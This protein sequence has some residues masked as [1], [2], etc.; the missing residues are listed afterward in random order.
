MPWIIEKQNMKYFILDALKAKIPTKLIEGENLAAHTR[1]FKTA[2]Y[3]Q[4]S[5]IG[6][7]WIL[8]KYVKGMPEYIDKDMASFEKCFKEDKARLCAFLYLENSDQVKYGSIMQNVVQQKSLGNDQYTKTIAE[9]NNV[10]S[11]HQ[12]DVATNKKNSKGNHQET[13]KDKDSYKTPNLLLLKWKGNVTV[14][15][16]SS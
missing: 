13:T 6:S 2:K 12:F 16:R 10:L 11:T 1:R 15:E 5:H 8:Y 9:A 14:M 4:K 3:V 7:D